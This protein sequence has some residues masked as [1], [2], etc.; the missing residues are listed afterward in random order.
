MI[1]TLSTFKNNRINYFKQLLNFNYPFDI[2]SETDKWQSWLPISAFDTEEI[3]NNSSLH[4]EILP[5]EWVFDLDSNGWQPVRKLALNLEQLFAKHNIVFD[6]WSSGN[7]I[8]YH[9]FID[10]SE[11]VQIEPSWLKN[12]LRFHFKKLLRKDKVSTDE[13]ILLWRE[14]HRSI[15]LLLIRG[16]PKIEGASIDLQKFSSSRCLIRAEGSL[17]LKTNAYKTYL[18]ELP[19]DQLLIKE[20]EKVEFPEKIAF[21]KPDP[22]FYDNMFLVTY[23]NFVKPKYEVEANRQR[24]TTKHEIGWIEDILQKTFSDGRKR[25]LDLII[26]PYLLNI[27][28]VPEDQALDIAFGWSLKCHNVEPIRINGRCV[29]TAALQNYIKYKLRR[30]VRIGLMPLSKENVKKWFGDCEEILEVIEKQKRG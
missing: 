7:W 25:L 14:V 24:A 18:D 22:K 6:R 20:Q 2:W 12:L 1:D 16:M 29:S 27:K 30:T 4:R 19:V 21:W 11:L 26:S 9:V 15:P 3:A 5:N 23:W 28:Q 8:H 10:D 17:N 13:V